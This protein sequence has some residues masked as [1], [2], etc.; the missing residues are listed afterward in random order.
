MRVRNWR[1]MNSACDQAGK[2]SH[3]HQVQR[4][5]LVGDLPHAGEIDDAG[6]GAAAADDHLGPLF[7]SKLL[8]IVVV[9]GLSFL[10]HAV[11]NDA[12]SFSG[13]VEMVPVGEV[14]AVRQVQ[15]ENGVAGLQH[16]GVGFHVGLR[17][18]VGLYV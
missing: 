4:A 13:K 17:T 1:G 5:D 7:F 8:Q 15:T 14:S 2:V 12:I 18:G 6:I 16:G 3:V 11:G 10:G 9:D